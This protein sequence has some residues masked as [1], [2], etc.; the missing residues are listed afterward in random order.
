MSFFSNK[1][2]IN[3]TISLFTALE[4]NARLF[5]IVVKIIVLLTVFSFGAQWYFAS[6]KIP[7]APVFVHEKTNIFPGQIKSSQWKNVENLYSQ[8]VDE[9]SLFENFGT[10]G[11][12][13]IGTN[14]HSGESLI[15]DPVPIT[16]EEIEG[17][18]EDQSGGGGGS[19][20]G[21]DESKPEE[22]TASSTSEVPEETTASSTPDAQEADE[23]DPQA[24]STE[25][26]VTQEPVGEA[27]EASETIEEEIIESGVVEEEISEPEPEPSAEEELDEDLVSEPEEISEPEPEEGPVVQA[28]GPFR[29]A[30]FLFSFAN[31]VAD[32][33]TPEELVEVTPEPEEV[34]EIIAQPI[35]V[36][37]TPESEVAPVEDLEEETEPEVH[38]QTDPNGTFCNGLSS[39]VCSPHIIE[40]ADFGIPALEG[41]RKVSNLQLRFSLAAK[42]SEEAQA[43][44]AGAEQG[45]NIEYTF[46]DQ[47]RK[48][49]DLV[50]DGEI[51]NAINGGYFLYGLPAITKTKELENFKVRFVY[52]GEE[53]LLDAIYLDALWLEMDTQ[54]RY[55]E[56]FDSFAFLNRLDSEAID[57]LRNP[58]LHELLS[59]K[60][61]FTYGELPTF[62]LRYNSQKNGVTQLFRSLFTEQPAV[63]NKISFTHNGLGDMQFSPIVNMTT[64]GLWTVQLTEAD[65]EKLH[66]GKY[67]VEM[68][69]AEGD[70]SYVDTFEF[71]WGLLT[72][73]P[74]Q[75]TYTLGDTA[76]MH[77]G[78]I[79]PTG[80]TLCDA[81]LRLSI[82]DPFG[83]MEQAVVEQSGECNGNNVI[84]VPDYSA[85]YVPVDAGEYTMYL[86]SLDNNGDVIA[87]T[88]DTFWVDANPAIVIQRTGPTRIYPLAEYDKELHVT[89][90]T[91]DF[92]GRLIERV[93]LGYVITNT[94]ADIDEYNEYIQLTWDISVDASSTESFGYTFD[95]PDVSP[96]LYLHGPAELI[97]DYVNASSTGGRIFEEHRQWQVASDAVPNQPALAE[98]PAFDNILATTTTPTFG[99]FAAYDPEADPV[100]F[101]LQIDDDYDFSS[102]ATTTSSLNFPGDAGWSAATFA[103]GATTT[104]TLQAS[105]ALSAGTTY[106]WRVRASDGGFSSYSDIRSMIIGTS[107]LSEWQQSEGYQFE[108]GTLT[109]LS[110]TT[111]T[112]ELSEL[113]GSPGDYM[114]RRNNADTTNVTTANLDAL[115]DTEVASSGDSISYSAGTYTLAEGKYLVMYGEYFDTADTNNNQ[116]VEIQGRLV[117]DGAATTTGAG[118]GFIRRQNFAQDAT[119]GGSSILDV[120]S[121]GTTLET[122]FYRTDTSADAGGT[123][124]RV[125]GW[126]G[127]SILRLSSDWD[128]GRYTL[129]SAATP[130]DGYAQLS[131]TAVHEEDTASFSQ[132]GADITVTDAGRYLV[133]YSIPIQTDGGSDRTEYSSKLQ[134][135]NVDVEGTH[136]STYMRENESTDDGVL[137]YIGI[138]DIGASEVLDVKVDMTDGTIT[139]H[140][141]EAGSSIEIVKFPSGNQ[142]IIA[143]ATS[144]EMNPAT[145]TEFAW[146]TTAHIDID[147][148]TMAAGTDSFMEVDVEGDYLFF[149]SQQT[150]NGGVRTVP[151]GRFSVNDVIAATAVS[152]KYN[153][154]NGGSDLAGYSLG[155]LIPGL[156]SGD[157]ISLETIFT[158]QGQ[159]TQT[160]D[161]GAMSGVQLDSLFADVNTIM[162]P[163]IDHDWVPNQDTWGSIEWNTTEPAGSSALLRVYYTNTTACDTLIPDGDLTGNAAGY[164]TTSS[165]LTI[166]G[167][168]TSTYNQICVQMTLDKGSAVTSPTLDDWK[169]GWALENQAPEIPTLTETPAFEYLQST[170]TPTF[171]GF[172]TTDVEGNPIEYEFSID[173]DVTFATPA[174]TTLS[175]N[176]PTDAGWS[177]ATFA[178]N[179]T[180]T[181]TIQ[182]GDALTDGV[183][184]FW[185]VRARDPLGSNSFSD[186][187]EVRTVTINAAA[188]DNE[189][190]QTLGVQFEGGVLAGATTTTGSVELSSP[191]TY[192]FSTTTE[193]FN[194]LSD[195]ATDFSSTNIWKQAV[196]TGDLGNW[197][198][199][200]ADTGS[201]G[202]GPDVSAEGAAY[203]YTEASNNQSCDNQ[204]ESTDC[205]IEADFVDGTLE[206]VHFEYHMFGANM[207][208]LSLDL[209]DGSTWTTVWSDTGSQSTD[210]LDWLDSGY[211]DLSSS[212]A[213]ATVMRFYA[214]GDGG[215]FS[216]DFALDNIRI[217]T[218]SIAVATVMSEEI[219]FAWVSGQDSWGDIQ[220]NVTEP[221]GS[222][223]LL[224]VY[225]TAS[226]ACDTIV[227]DGVIPG[228]SSGFDVS[229]SGFFINTV[230]TSTYDRLCL[231]MT[232]DQGTSLTSPTLD[233]W[234]VRWLLPDQVPFAPTFDE[235]PAFDS[236]KSTTTTPTFGGFAAG[237]FE[238]DNLEYEIALDTD[239]AFG[240]PD[241][242]KTSSDFPTDAGWSAATFTANATTT[243][244]VQPADALDNGETY[245]YRVRA[246]DP[247]GSNTWGDYSEIQSITIS[248]A[249]SFSEWYQ[250]EDGQF[251]SGAVLD[252]ATTSGSGGIIIE[253]L[254]SRVSLLDAWETGTTRS[255]VSSGS[256]RLLIVGIVNEDSGTDINVDTVEFGGQQLTEIDDRQIGTGFSNGM[257]VGYLDEA[258]IASS[259]GTTIALTGAA[260]TANNGTAYTSAIFEN[261]DQ[262]TPIRGDS[263]NALTSGTNITAS[264]A[265][266]VEDGDMMFYISESTTGVSHTAATGY[267]EGTQEDTAGDEFTMASAYKAITADGSEYPEAIWSG[268]GNRLLMVAGAIQPASTLA[269]VMSQEV[270]FD[271][272]ENQN[273]WGEVI[274]NGD[275]PSG[276]TVR[277]QVYYTSATACDTLVPNGDLSGN[278]TGFVLTDSPA[279]I[280]GLSTSTYNR[281]CLQAELDLG[282]ASSSPELTDWNVSWELKP[283]FEQVA[284]A[285]Y[286]NED[287]ITPTD[288]WPEGVTAS[289]LAQDEPIVAEYPSKTGDEL[290]LRMGI[291]VASTNANGQA[292]KLQFAEGETCSPVLS[293]ID[294]G[295]AGSSTALWAGYDNASVADGTTLSSG[296]L[297]STTDLQSYEEENDSV[298]LPNAFNIGEFAEHDWTLVNQ[299]NAGTSYCFRMV[300]SDGVIFKTYDEYPQLVTNIAPTVAAIALPFDNQKVPSQLPVFEFT[301]VD[302]E[303]EEIHYQIQ[304]DTDA[305]FGSPVIDANSISNFASF[306]NLDTF[307]DKS[308]FNDSE[309][310]RYTPLLSLVDGS[311]YWWRVRALDS[312]GS[313][314]YGNWTTARSL[315]VDTTLSLTTWH[316][317]T[318]EQFDTDTLEDTETLG[319]DNVGVT[320]PFTTGTTTSSAID[321][322]DV[323]SGNAWGV[324]S[325][326]ETDGSSEIVYHIEYYTGSD[327]DL[328]PDTALSGNAVGFASTTSLLDLDTETYNQIRIRANFTG[329]T[330]TLDDWTVSWGERVSVPTHLLL[331]DNEKM[332]TT[333][334]TFTFFTT[335]PQDEDLEYEFSYS[336]DYTFVGASTTLNSGVDAGFSNVTNPSATTS[337]YDSGDTISYD[338]QSALTDG[339]TYWW[340]VRAQDP[341]GGASFSF[342]SDPWSFTV[343]ATATTSTW[344]QTT[345]EQFETN[346]LSSLVASGDSV[347]TVPA[348]VTTYNFTDAV[349]HEA[350]D[351]EIA[352]NDPT[353]PPSDNSIDSITVTGTNVGDPNL[354]SGIAG[355]ASDAEASGAQYTAIE[356]SDNSRWQITDPGNGDDAV[357][358]AEIVIAEDPANISQIDLLLEG[359]QAAATDK[360][361]FGIWRPGTST[362]YW[363]LLEAST[364]TGDYDYTGTITSNIDE[365]FDGGNSIHLIFYNEDDSDSLFV[366]YVEAVVTSV[367]AQEGT[368]TSTPVDFDDGNGPAWGQLEWS[369]TVTPPEAITY[370]VEYLNEI[371]EWELIPEIALAGNAT[372][373]SSSPVDLKSLNTTTYNELRLI[374]NI[375]CDG[376]SCPT[377]DDWT[378]EW[379]RGFEVSGIAYNYDG[380]ST[381]TSGT[382]LIAV[383]G[384]QQPSKTATIAGDGTWSFDNI[385]FFDGDVITVFASTSVAADQMMGVTVYDGTPEITG[386]VLQKQHLTLGSDDNASVTNA[387][388]GTYDSAND[389]RMFAAVDGGNDL[390]LCTTSGCETAGLVVLANNAYT[391]ESGADLITH[392]VLN[393]G[394]VTLIDNTLRVSGSWDDNATTSMAASTVIMTATSTTESIDTTGALA[395]SFNNLIFGETSGAATWN[396][397]NAL[398]VD[399]DL[400]I[401][402]GTVAR[403]TQEITIANDLNVGAAGFISG[404]ATT[405]FDGSS[406]SI[407][408]DANAT[409]QNIGHTVVD[410][411]SHI[412]LLGSDTTAQS[413]TVVSGNTIDL[414]TGS[415]TLTVLEG[416]QNLGTLQSQNSAVDFVATTAGQVINNTTGAFYDLTFSGV[417]GGWSFTQSNLDV[418]H[419]VSIATGTVTMP[420][421]ITTIGGSFVNTGGLFAHNNATIEFD[422]SGSETITALGTAFNNAFYDLDFTGSGSW[423]VTDTNA[424]SS[425][426]VSITG[427]TLVLPTGT[428]TV[429]GSFSNTGGVVTHNNGTLEMN[430]ATPETLTLNGS[431]LYDLRTTGSGTYTFNEASASIDN[432]LLIDAGTVTLPSGTLSLG[433]SIANNGTISAPTGNVLFNSSDAGETVDLGASSLFDMTFNSATGGWNIIANATSTGDV[434]LTDG[435]FTN[436]P[437]V[438]LSVGDVFTNT[439]GG[440]STTWTGST[441]SLE[442]GIYTINAKGDMGDVYDTLRLSATAEVSIWNSSAT[443]ATVTSGGSLY[444]QDHAETDG[445]LHIY[446][447]YARTSGAE[448]WSYATD[449]DG[450]DLSGGSERLADVRFAANATAALTDSTLEVLGSASASS[451]IQNQGAGTYT[452]SV[453]GGT[454][455]A[456]YYDFANLGSTGV[457][458][459]ASTSVTSLTDGA[460]EVDAPAGSAVTVSADTV[461]TNPGLQIY[462]TTFSTSTAIAAFNVSQTG[463]TP[464][465]YWWFRESVGNLTGEANDSDTGDP[466]SVRWDDSSLTVAVSGMVYSDD[467]VTALT[468]GTCSS[469][470][471][472]RLVVEGGATYDAACT[473]GAGA[474][475]FPAVAIIGNPTI[476]VFL[477]GA[478]GG[479]EAVTVTKTVTAAVTDLDLYVNRVIVRHEDAD[480]M[481]IADMTAYDSSDDVEV[482]FAAATGTTDTLV[483]EGDRELH[484]WASS[485]FTPGG[486]VTL[487]SGSTGNPYDGSL[488]IAGDATFTAAGTTTY[489]VGGSFTQDTGATFIPASSTVLMN[490]TTGGKTITSGTGET[491]SFN[492]LTFNG[493][494]GAWNVNGDIEAS[495]DILVSDGT[496][497]GTGDITLT[498][499]SFYGNGLVSL[500]GGTTTIATSNT[501]GGT[502]AWTFYDLTLGNGLV[503]GTTTP[504]STATTTVS[505]VFTIETA[506]FFDAGSARLN[507][508]GDGVVFVENGTFFEDTSTVRYS[509][510]T[511][512]DILATNYYNLELAGSAGTPTYTATGVGISVANDLTVGGA[513]A[514][515]ANFDTNDTVLNVDGD[516]VITSNG[517]LVGS[518]NAAFTAAGSWDNDGVYTA[519]NGTVV[520][521]GTGTHTIA[522]GSSDFASVDLTGF[523]AF[524]LSEHATATDAFTLS[525]ASAFT[526]SN[527]ESLAVGGTFTNNIGGA[528]T[529]WTGTT[530]SLYGGGN[531][532]VNSATTTELY[533]TV[534]VGSNTDVRMWNSSAS[535]TTT[536]SG[537]SLYSM[538]HA[539]VD[540]DLYIFGDY[541]KNTGTDHWSYET[542]FDGTDLSGGSE[543]MVDVAIAGGGGVLY[544]SGG[545]LSVLGISTAS[546]TV[547]NQG[548]GVYSFEIGNT[549]ST[550][551]LYYDYADMDSAGLEFS[552]SP[553]VHDLSNG[554]YLIGTTAYSGMTVAASAIVANP[555]LT[556][557]NNIFA[558]SSGV[559]VAANVTAT[560]VSVSSWRFTNHSGNFDGEAYDID[561]DGD[562]GYIVWDDSAASITVSGNVYLNEGSTASGECDGLTNNVHLRIAGLTS[563]TTSCDATTGAYSISSVAYS[564]GDSL[565]V[566]LDDAGEKATTVTEDPIS[567]ISNM[568]L[569][570]NRVIV[571]HEG[572]DSLSIDDMAV[573][574]SSDDGDILFT[575]AG[576]SPDTLTIP[577]DTKLIVWDNKEFEPSG[578]VTVS[579]GV[580]TDALNGTV[581]LF[582]GA[583][584]TANGTEE[585]SIGGS[586]ILDSGASFDAA[587]STTTFTTTHSGRTIDMNTDAFH[588]LA[589]TGSGSWGVTDATL[590]AHDITITAGTLT[591]P[592]GTTT[593]SGSLNNSAGTITNNGS[594]MVF[595]ATATSKVINTNGS[596]L[597]SMT[598]TG[599]GS[600]AMTDV[601][602]TSLGSVTISD[603]TVT[604]PS[605]VLTVG[606]DFNNASGTVTH[607]TSEIDFTSNTATILHANGSDLGGVRF[608]GTGP[609]T[610][611]DASLAITEDLT[612]D[613]G[614][615][616]F[617]TGTL[618]LGGSF[619][620]SGGTFAHSSGTILFNSGDTG[621][622]IDPGTSDF[623]NLV[624]GN[625]SGGWTIG[626]NATTTNNFT[627]STASSFTMGSGFTLYVGNVF[628]NAVGGVATTWTG[629]TLTLDAGADYAINSKV[630]GGDAYETLNIITDTDISMWNSSATTTNIIANGSM[631]SQDHAAVDGALNIYGD[632]HI[633]TTTEYWSYETDFD[634]V[635][636]IGGGERAVTVSIAAGATTTVDGGT[637]NIEGASGF[638]TTITNQGSGTYAHTITSG[639]YNAIYYAFRNLDVNGVNFSGAPTISSLTAGDYELAVGGGSLITLASSTLNANASAVITGVRFATTTAITGSNLT[640]VGSTTNAWTFIGHTGNLSGE[641]FDVDGATACGSIRWDDSSCLLTQQTHYRWRNDDGGIGAPDS[642]WYN[643]SWDKRK[644]VRVQNMDATTYTD[645]V[646][647]MD[648]TY[649]ANMQAGFD[650]LRFTD[651]SGTTTVPFWIETFTTSATATVWVQVPTLPANDF[652]TVFMYYNNA[653]AMSSSSITDTFIVGDDFEDADIA[654]YS[655]DTGKFVVDGTYA[656]GGSYGLDNTGNETLRA[657]DGIYDTTATTS[658]GEIIRYMQYVNTSGGGDEVCTMFAVQDPGSG[659][660]NYAVCTEQVPGTDRISLARDVVETDTSGTVLASTSVTYT[661]GWYEIEIDWQTSDDID[662]T[663]SKDGVEVASI[664]ANDS[665]Y[666]EGGIG[667][668]YWFNGGGWDGYTS[669]ARVDTEPTIYFGAEQVD[670]GAT[671]AA[672]L[673]TGTSEF[674]IGETARLRLLVENSGLQVTGQTY[675]LEYAEQGVAPS[676]EAVTAASYAAV[677]PQASCGSSPV[678]MQSSANVTDG[679]A[680]SDL[681]AVANGTFTLGELTEDPSNTADS[682]TIEQ[683]AYTE[684]E[685]VLTPTVNVVDENMCFR[686]SNSGSDLDTYLRVAPL[687]IRFDPSFGAVTFNAGADISLVA[688]TTTRVYATSTATDLNGYADLVLGSSTMYTTAAGAV[689]T[690]DN[691]DCYVET[692]AS[693]CS[694]S[695]CSGNSCTL[696][697]YADFLYH[698]DATD[699]DG[700]NEW[701]AFLEVED[702]VGGYGFGTS[703]SVEVATLRALEVNNSIDYGAVAVSD[704]T[705]AINASTTVANIGN[706]AIDIDIVGDDLDDGYTSSIPAAQQIFAT[707]TFD[708]TTC[709]ACTNLSTSSIVYEVDLSKPT[710]TSPPVTD[711][712]FWGI[713]IPFGAASNAH[714]GFNTFYAVSD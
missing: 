644:R 406:V 671:W 334:P 510:T 402:Y 588:N 395:G 41:K 661:S 99:G 105:D 48:S 239:F 86:E 149:A 593:V 706:D 37:P 477:N 128:Y 218:S 555:A 656:F 464:S 486:T 146:D 597:A 634:G 684:L 274:W 346:T 632:Y 12:A 127:V 480:P 262:T 500:G 258:G 569:Y 506:H 92:R 353:D 530:L 370:Q 672:D 420:T 416:W 222:D 102:P 354:R 524:T 372:G 700:A 244:T 417:S 148:F 615:V 527:G 191:P 456:Q 537:G 525:N 359:Y 314:T 230:S 579:G 469:G 380:I 32:I 496:V 470:T 123:V 245:F 670:G 363:E 553:T 642:E 350:R 307:S 382:L 695:D 587:N 267:T 540:G 299:A 87:H 276:S 323:V 132:S 331:F 76:E 385:T 535:T 663:L 232:L 26:D 690:A 29:V 473:G 294:V 252:N 147:A 445:L 522:A 263:G 459:L 283:A 561:P 122:R 557:T 511:A 438:T 625:G 520:F 300:N 430:S 129:S 67:T 356:A 112:V 699:S 693:Q 447:D 507:L 497:T 449:F 142:T 290:R 517:T 412:L 164:A 513:V 199:E 298:A 169:V 53:N 211:V 541:E 16:Q 472:I 636:L 151:A 157:D 108:T 566:Y 178:D 58:Q 714:T 190:H 141:M 613:S 462:G 136:V 504:A 326:G 692:T 133:S 379:S 171:G 117:I 516:I 177:A 433:G 1:T 272:V 677:P 215:G 209:Y 361:W 528:A 605:G 44:L 287:A 564:P 364:Q 357:F 471:P 489:T 275:E 228:N 163:E 554:S 280:S 518:D 124:D 197:Q 8:N 303:G 485:T 562:P 652:A 186:Y 91:D 39:D 666:T 251:P 678:C 639:T 89:A 110:T 681:L 392:D 210:E 11:S 185:R 97:A 483:V 229:E 220:W 345:D 691:N 575:A 374:G 680:T 301:G 85:I 398:D 419:D 664:T 505:G 238:N 55:R 223:T 231:Q 6:A 550:T 291:G 422:G 598:F 260:P 376:A 360:A 651:S 362:P 501:L 627:L 582:N 254:V 519:S 347:S 650:D 40:F 453:S 205:A 60:L 320:S 349:T 394:T 310:I 567:S 315:T 143:E 629:S 49:G 121:D 322:D 113:D 508:A 623:Y 574:D 45:I 491:I 288:T 533:A 584:W 52:Y 414:S 273:D 271:W 182:A 225:H 233:D 160:M 333:L 282:T 68:V 512:S 521:D 23:P 358:W 418:N 156:S 688:G 22:V 429:G 196:I 649:D 647:K 2:R 337:P 440:A 611:T 269:T 580:A 289:E 558:T 529:T 340:R 69:I 428:F 66:P 366:D 604:L 59:N 201:N 478:V 415:R 432:D 159:V 709:T 325:A 78:A 158:E 551:M 317:T 657:V 409:E 42:V 247:L 27:E 10:N 266:T 109:G 601:N 573:W 685:Y 30:S 292:F 669:R 375:E 633:S 341:A 536:Q 495:A 369:D 675:L 313:E 546:T 174:T 95:A 13:F 451:T 36:E 388:I 619:D 165:P 139:G 265:V 338:I 296:V 98:T 653:V 389:S 57:N 484:I 259:S 342:W 180:T 18:P 441:L 126:G 193:T 381:T 343:D 411:T 713:A 144:G 702:A 155:T 421:G 710:T 548:S 43:L 214:L 390:D 295:P 694:F 630:S 600:W 4:F 383:D 311:T 321:F 38:P 217:A 189:W 63:V 448:Y 682:L 344:F 443:T 335:D 618:S 424:S 458:L 246:R 531:Y 198:A 387:D 668:T 526:L 552:G 705:G 665:T 439:L 192:L 213:T 15:V 534:A 96:F 384:V 200:T 599:S 140:V 306:T 173:N 514:S 444:S 711:D 71:Q 435:T 455:T 64:D 175:S 184:Y 602:V 457:N 111:G 426:D 404:I 624:F 687:T 616:I 640:L 509:G 635:N 261:V 707:S 475:T 712:I 134:L 523:G 224:R 646:V 492:Q 355:Y 532:L 88:E 461:D 75:A 667:F 237:D 543:R 17:D 137:S 318:Q 328:I 606:G 460:F 585:Y 327:W 377:L 590:S 621:E 221:S 467:G 19:S 547:A 152:G 270:D 679:E 589:F 65:K 243:Y 407:W 628:S 405:T 286:A 79:T 596:S 206:G 104:Y 103:S 264:A 73:N 194:G 581:Q 545:A 603:G 474:F 442:N 203:I 396:L 436:D 9:D 226:T 145:L 51:S 626:A 168:S 637:L 437:G 281:I 696:S 93:P 138:I 24:T 704:N 608:T 235:L 609:Y 90:R 490:A 131:W 482:F 373:F 614:S 572:S 172:V 393:D 176:Y 227:P 46:G 250:T 47:W 351:F 219:D 114:V 515:T 479:E 622:S 236:M 371:D 135:N 631:Y 329:A 648:V 56:L 571:R 154:S 423:T 305:N 463:G 502:Q 162:S 610:M 476:T 446:G 256:N 31:A 33:V 70:D 130:P 309:E 352:V 161:H 425:N 188:E 365:Y 120:A 368:I 249:I 576:G 297:A 62:A 204:G 319:T 487:T 234:T 107:S 166:S 466:G 241:L 645:A 207:G 498:N 410:G 488:H 539:N 277:M 556:F 170:T 673:D 14:V 101:E 332:E 54:T 83:F 595:T 408:T 80:D 701:W 183:T 427:G 21:S 434:T 116:R 308:P 620:G 119:V 391:P 348:A 72:I 50:I 538:D 330:P 367:T 578:D 544:Q 494:G 82:V 592:V 641:D 481:T 662:V 659:N 454:T 150:A 397:T 115:W 708:Y 118:Q 594:P 195:G 638:E 153:R 674:N 5:S 302:P 577:A 468:A 399:G 586:F 452:V 339:V 253:D 28:T 549:G 570:E 20:G 181:Y 240:S 565:V 686:V 248:T 378:I 698:A 61:D 35:T 660:N 591:L 493:T 212:R 278:G 401:D 655:G 658:Q 77:M 617:A 242:T 607:N 583:T 336:T 125:A 25:S 403:T 167:L 563:Y 465:S 255:A 503:V 187:S 257:W 560:G 179:A 676:C 316:Q 293:W 697:C 386:M 324:F 431:A 703:P 400:T 559:T 643:T 94:N 542:D 450:A 689:C 499:G 106:Y 683:D 284:Y 612:I 3:S 285:W 34:P 81:D 202:T 84:D 568:D 413:V 208:T 74:L 279:D 312:G 268:A 304:V 7:T 654:E 100:S 216:G